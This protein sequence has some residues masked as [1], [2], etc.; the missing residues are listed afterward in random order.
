MIMTIKQQVIKAIQEMDQDV[1]FDEIVAHLNDLRHQV[2]Q[3][4]NSDKL[5]T[6]FQNSPLAEVEIDLE[7]D[8]SQIRNS[9]I[10]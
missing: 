1:T 2:Q 8:K 5:S 10:I 6:F 4:T 9:E 3:S 7:R